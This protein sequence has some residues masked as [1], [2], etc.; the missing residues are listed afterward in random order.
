MTSTINSDPSRVSGGG[1]MTDEPILGYCVKC[2][3]KREIAS[4]QAVFLG[5]Q[6]R[7]ATKGTC[8]QCGTKITRF[9]RTPAHEGLDRRGY[10]MSSV[11][12]ICGTQDVHNELEQKMA[13]FLGKEDCILFANAN[14]DALGRLGLE[15]LR[16][17]LTHGGGVLVMGGKAAYA[18]GGWT[19]YLEDGQYRLDVQKGGD[20]FQL[21]KHNLTVTRNKKTRVKVTFKPAQV[22]GAA[23]TDRD[24]P[25]SIV[26]VPA[27]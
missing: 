1:S 10:G 5:D 24:P 23:R 2:R 26:K 25:P 7:P 8:P 13:K 11:R 3:E 20:R 16:D 21:D 9:G 27:L 4:P 14:I 12:F 6:S 18:A 19:A 17:Y 15:M 22:A